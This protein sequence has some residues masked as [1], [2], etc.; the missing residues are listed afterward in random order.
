MGKFTERCIENLLGELQVYAERANEAMSLIVDNFQLTYDEQEDTVDLTRIE[1]PD[2][3]GSD[4]EK[5]CK[6]GL[7]SY[8]GIIN[9]DIDNLFENYFDLVESYFSEFEEKKRCTL[10][11]K[12]MSSSSFFIWHQSLVIYDYICDFKEQDCELMETFEGSYANSVLCII[13]DFYSF[14][15]KVVDL[16]K[17][18]EIDAYEIATSL[19]ST[20][21]DIELSLFDKDYIAEELIN[22]NEVIMNWKGQNNVLTDMFRQAKNKGYLTNSLPDIAIF[23]KENFSCFANTKLSTIETQLKNNNSSANAFPKE[24]KRIKIDN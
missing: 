23:L 1:H 17:I 11:R 3:Y 4:F 7:E 21:E 13:D 22:K 14:I 2:W 24:E 9:N 16:C 10:L 5:E 6:V 15:R 20:S 8:E 19:F 12:L 18:Y